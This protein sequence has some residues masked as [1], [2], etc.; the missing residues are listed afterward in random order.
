METLIV[1][2]DQVKWN[3]TGDLSFTLLGE[4]QL[5]SPGMPGKKTMQTLNNLE[6]CCE[7]L[8]SHDTEKVG[9]ALAFVEN[10]AEV[11]TQV[12]ERYL[13]LIRARLGDANATLEKFEEGMLSEAQATLLD[14]NLG[15]EFIS[16]ARLDEDESNVIVDFI[17]SIT[18]SIV[19]IEGY[20]SAAK[21]CTDDEGFWE[22]HRR[23]GSGLK[24]KI[25]ER[26]KV[27]PTGWFS[28]ALTSLVGMHDNLNRVMFE[29]SSFEPNA[30]T[31]DGFLFF[32]AEFTFEEVRVDVYQSQ[33]TF[34]E[35]VWLL[36][37]LLNFDWNGD[38]D[39]TPENPLPY[40]RE[41][42]DL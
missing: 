20:I 42:I 21:Q 29:K 27:N 41:R 9:T 17:G 40:R 28:Q 35:T 3:A 12:E 1:S 13:P 4:W 31:I 2:G 15:S 30:A 7:Y 14:G 16:F 6:E 32:L 11:K 34:P 39:A 38:Y 23:Y 19:N 36:R 37:T 22:V 10:N 33:V 18:H 5:K 25:T 24:E 26:A 8:E